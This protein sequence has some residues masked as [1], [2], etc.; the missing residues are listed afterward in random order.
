M[1]FDYVLSVSRPRYPPQMYGVPSADGM[2]A[3]RTTLCICELSRYL[4]LVLLQLHH[5]HL[6]ERGSNFLGNLGLGGMLDPMRLAP[7]GP[8]PE[9]L[10][11]PEDIG[12]LTNK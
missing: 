2:H 7:L 9:F 1:T 8:I 10:P 3:L 11:Q 4:S 6:Q 5:A 12:G